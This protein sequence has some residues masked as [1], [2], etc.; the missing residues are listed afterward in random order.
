M[1]RVFAAVLF[2]AAFVAFAHS[3]AQAMIEFCPA[4]VDMAAVGAKAGG[5]A[6]LY[7]FELT[8]LGSRTVSGTIAF[9]TDQGWYTADLPAVGLFAKIRTYSSI[10]TEFSRRDFVSPRMYVNFPVKV[11]IRESWMYRAS[12]LNDGAFG[13]QSQG[14]V[15]CPP[16]VAVTGGFHLK[17]PD[18]LSA[19][20]TASSLILSPIAS[21]P[22]MTSNCAVPYKD[23]TVKGSPA[24]PDWPPNAMPAEP[25]D[26][27]VKVAINADGSLADAWLYEPSGFP[28]MDEAA[29]DAAKSTK[30]L[31]AIMYCTPTPC[32]VCVQGDVRSQQ[33]VT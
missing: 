3:R 7:G 9:D 13:W 11:K 20:A 14:T 29:I 5:P 30:Y 21:A 32:H 22:L 18:E 2:C 15:Q 1:K 8:A 26:A 10:E 17:D 24:S 19:P 28:S 33:V 31:P 4:Q 27:A 23:A 16:Q 12:A 6:A 25:A